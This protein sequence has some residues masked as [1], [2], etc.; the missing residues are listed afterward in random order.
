MPYRQSLVR[1]DITAGPHHLGIADKWDGGDGDSDIGT[2]QRASG[3]VTLGGPKTRD[4]AT[5]T[6]LCDEAF[7]AVWP[8]LDRGRGSLRSSMVLTPVGDDGTPFASGSVTLT[9]T[10]KTVPTP[11]GDFSSNEGNAIALVFKMD[12]ERA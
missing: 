8:A 12:A 10:L 5:A 11:S 1:A 3:E 6:Y 2:Y 9:G 7:W 4:D